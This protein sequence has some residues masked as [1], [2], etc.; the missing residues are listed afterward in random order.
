MNLL[1][2]G[3]VAIVTGGGSGIGLA[4][5]QMLAME[6]ASVAIVDIDMDAGNAAV[7][8]IRQSGA[9]AFFRMCD[10]SNSDSVKEALKKTVKTYGKLDC[11][12]NN[13]GIGSSADITEIK[14]DEFDRLFAINV[15]GVYL[16]LKYGIRQ[17][18]KQNTGGAIVN[19][20][21]V[22]GVVGTPHLSAYT[23]SKHAVVG[24][25]RA[26]AVE[27]G[28][29]GIRVNAICPGPIHTEMIEEYA[30]LNN[31]TLGDLGKD[32]PLRKIGQPQDVAGAVCWLCSDRSCNTT[33]SLL[34]VDGG[35]TAQ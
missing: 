6:G 19:I 33:G 15:K 23:M 10:V 27:Q 28:P 5:S 29:N 1:C 35:Y 3:K 31:L 7:E 34:M 25:T 9:N 20:A 12:I 26:V 18:H 24:L 2:D 32:L 8:T 17:I 22:G 11:I 16:F 13:A 14:D 30:Q 21:S 4:I